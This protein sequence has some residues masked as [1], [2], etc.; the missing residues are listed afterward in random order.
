MIINGVFHPPFT[1]NRCYSLKCVD[2]HFLETCFNN[3]PAPGRSFGALCRA[4]KSGVKTNRLQ[5]FSSFLR[6]SINDDFTFSTD[7]EPWA[8]MGSAGHTEQPARQPHL[9]GLKC[10]REKQRPPTELSGITA[11]THGTNNRINSMIQFATTTEN[12]YGVAHLVLYLFIC[13]VIIYLFKITTVFITYI[14]LDCKNVMVR[15]S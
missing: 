12:F 4:V 14:L 1:S 15:V 7:R 10:C 13:L 11:H 3:L 9:P 8:D 5:C 6:S 2:W